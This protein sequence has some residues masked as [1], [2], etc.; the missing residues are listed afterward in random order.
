MFW[1]PTSE[2]DILNIIATLNS[3]AAPDEDGI[4]IKDL[5]MVQHLIAPIMCNI[6]FNDQNH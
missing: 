4:A 5:E 6:I 1:R 3:N 2:E